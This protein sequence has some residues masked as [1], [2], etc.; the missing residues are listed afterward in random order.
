[1]TQTNSLNTPSHPVSVPPVNSSSQGLEEALQRINRLASQSQ[2]A[3]SL[4]RPAPA[5]VVTAST[6]PT[7][8][9]AAFTHFRTTNNRNEPVIPIQ[10]TSLEMAGLSG[11]LVEEIVM[12]YLF[13]RGEAS[14]RA[15]AEQIKLPFGFVE[16]TLNRLKSQQLSGYL[17]ATAMNDYIHTDRK[18]VV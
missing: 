3:S 5:Q 14:G 1:M 6:K 2:N 18:S 15:I 17:G 12:R 13:N 8:A 7:E 16:P 9:S 4:H 10:P 11:Q